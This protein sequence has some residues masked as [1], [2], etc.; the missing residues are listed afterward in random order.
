MSGSKS[1]CTLGPVAFRDTVISHS[2]GEALV[3]QAGWLGGDGLRE[4]LSDHKSINK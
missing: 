1:G 2:E 4:L 3:I